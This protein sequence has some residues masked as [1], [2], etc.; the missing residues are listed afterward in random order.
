MKIAVFGLDVPVG[1]QKYVCQCFNELVEKFVPQKVTP[2]AVEFIGDDFDKADAVI[3]DS[4]RKFDFLFIDLDKV[5]TRL[6]RTADEKERV[7]LAKAQQLLEKEVLLFEADLAP[8][9]KELIK[10]L[11]FVSLKPCMGAASAGDMNG[12]IKAVMEKAGE[13]LFFTAGKKEVH[14]WDIKLGDNAVTAAG[15]IHSDLARGFIKAEIV[16]CRQLDKFFNMAEARA[17]GLV[18][19]VDRD[20]VM[21]PGDI[22]EVKFSV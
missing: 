19:A 11:Q 3:F 17:K 5:E 14:A 1:K 6:Q 7:V 18:K 22:I 13:I 8:D 16:N 2:Y 21:E 4:A 10:Q 12:L 15:R 20:Y 9:E